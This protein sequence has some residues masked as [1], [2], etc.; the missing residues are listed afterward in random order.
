MIAV[1]IPAHDEADLID[2]CLQLDFGC[3]APPR[4][5]GREHRRAAGA[6]PLHRCHRI[7]REQAPRCSHPV[8]ELSQRR[9]RTRR[10]R[11][12]DAGARC[13]L[14]RLHRCRHARQP[15]LAGGTV[16]DE[17]GRRLRLGGGGRLDAIRHGRHAGARALSTRATPMPTDTRTSTARTSAC[18]RRPMPCVVGSRRWLAARTWRWCAH[19]RRVARASRGVRHPAS[20]PARD[21]VRVRAADSATRWHACSTKRPRRPG[22]PLASLAGLPSRSLARRMLRPGAAMSHHFDEGSIMQAQEKNGSAGQAGD[23]R[24]RLVLD[25]GKLEAAKRSLDEGALVPSYGPW[26]E[27]VVKLLNDALATEIVCILRYKRHAVHCA[28]ASPRRRSPR[29]SW[30]MRRKRRRTPTASPSASCSSAAN[31]TSRPHTLLERSHADYDDST[32]LQAMIRANLSPSAWRSRPTR[33]M[34]NLIGDK[35]PTTRRLLVDVLSR[36]AGA[37]R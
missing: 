2:G 15:G 25:E 14:A 29:S 37:R 24:Q 4:V 5:A 13:A 28:R 3:G 10:R 9:A 34:I 17:G 27:D 18:R 26:R 33:Q 23:D 36:R 16:V 6:R 19:C 8:G 31:R 11:R 30:C 32:D 1:I 12:R 21:A 7:D 22:T 20:R 35:D